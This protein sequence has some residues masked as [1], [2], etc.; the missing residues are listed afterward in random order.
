MEKKRMFFIPEGGFNVRET[1]ELVY[2]NSS[3]EGEVF[4]KKD[5]KTNSAKCVLGTLSLLSTSKTGEEF[6]ITV[7][8]ED[9]ENVI[10]QIAHFIEKKNTTPSNLNLWDEEGIEYVNKALKESNSSWT[11]EVHNIAK[12]YLTMN[13]S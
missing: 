9:A 8:G 10:Q 4:V 5:N 2:Y 1:L 13:K 11:S 12:S 6:M 7:K 3:F